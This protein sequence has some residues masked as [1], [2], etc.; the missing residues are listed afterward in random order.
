MKTLQEGGRKGSNTV[1]VF[2][3]SFLCPPLPG[4]VG[5]PRAD[6]GHTPR[7]PRTPGCSVPTH[8]SWLHVHCGHRLT[9]EKAEAQGSW[10]PLK[11]NR[12][13]DQTLASKLEVP[14]SERD[15]G[16]SEGEEMWTP[17]LWSRLYS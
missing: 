2:P 3:N 12:W 6:A 4:T 13:L 16:G 5:S 14:H 7:W 15:S 1:M 10:G 17:N 9:H 8:T 11:S